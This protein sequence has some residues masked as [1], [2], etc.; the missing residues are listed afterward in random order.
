[1]KD[2]Y[3]KRI[4]EAAAIFPVGISALSSLQ[5]FSTFGVLDDIISVLQQNRL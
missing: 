3:L 5:C 4:Q 2:K 1:M